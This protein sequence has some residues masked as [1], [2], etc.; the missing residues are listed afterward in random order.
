MKRIIMS[1]AMLAS[2]IG[3]ATTLP[4]GFVYLKDIDPTIQ[5]DIRYADHHNFIGRPITGYDA[6]ECILSL[7]AAKALAEVQKDL[8][9]MRYSLKV[10]DCYRPQMAVDDFIHWSQQPDQQ[11]MKGEFYPRTAKTDFFS[12]GYVAKQSN[13]T[14]GSTVD[15]TIVPMHSESTEQYAQ[16]Q[17][18]TACFAPYGERFHDGSLD[19]GT[20]YDCMD[21]TAHGDNRDVSKIAQQHRAL[22]RQV[23]GKH[24][25]AP[26][27]VEWWHFTLKN[28]PY[29]TTFFNFKIPPTPPTL[30]YS[31]QI[32]IVSAD[33]RRPYTAILQRYQ[34]AALGSNWE[35]VG[36]PIPVVIGK[37]GLAWADSNS[38][39]PKWPVKK[40]GDM[41]TPIGIFPIPFAFG[42]MPANKS[43]YWLPWLQLEEGIECVDD[44]SSR[45]YNQI[46]NHRDTSLRDWHSSEKMAH[47]PLYKLG[48]VIGYNA[49][50][51]QPGAG[52]CIFLHIW[53]DAYSGTAGCVAM[54]EKNIRSV[55]KWLR[56]KNSPV[57]VIGTTATN[58][59]FLSH[60][61]EG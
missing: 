41:R 61:V 55:L 30:H 16:G 49:Q 12:L 27:A 53:R 32:L 20:G 11:Q 25:F 14:H 19:M 24:G 13:H 31:K 34:R 17:S 59:K 21:E 28:Q 4:H 54:D 51:R 40:E 48:A 60:S 43:I 57:I 47:V 10:Y 42:L 29:P 45:Y 33:N 8:H 23:M 7:P 5:Q 1:A 3:H 26:Y 52:S 22:L 44:P 39:S 58:Q 37:H 36:P 46:V 2:A 9:K 56:P 18:L 6:A 35:K 50:A 38:T 15:L